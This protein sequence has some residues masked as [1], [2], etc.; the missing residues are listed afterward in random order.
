[1]GT[2][3]LYS[4]SVLLAVVLVI[5]ALMTKNNLDLDLYSQLQPNR[6]LQLYLGAIKSLHSCH[7]LQRCIEE[8]RVAHIIYRLSI[9]LC[10]VSTVAVI[11]VLRFILSLLS[12]DRASL[13]S[14]GTIVRIRGRL[15]GIAVAPE[16]VEVNLCPQASVPSGPRYIGV[17]E[18]GRNSPIEQ[19]TLQSPLD[20]AQAQTR[21]I[22]HGVAVDP[23]LVAQELPPGAR[24]W[25]IS[26]GNIPEVVLNLLH[27]LW[28]L[29]CHLT[30][31][32]GPTAIVP[33]SQRGSSHPLQQSPP[34][35][36]GDTQPG[37]PKTA[38]YDFFTHRGV[39]TSLSPVPFGPSFARC[40]TRWIPD[41]LLRPLRGRHPTLFVL[42]IAIDEATH[43]LEILRLISEASK[44]GRINFSG[45]CKEVSLDKIYA[46]IGRLYNESM[47]IPGSELLILLTGH[48]DS[49]NRMRLHGDEFIDETDLYQFFEQLK[50]QNTHSTVIP[51]ILFDICREGDK[52][53]REPP[54]GIGLLWSCSSG[55]YAHAFRLPYNPR[56]PH[57]CFLLALVMGSCI[58]DPPCTSETFKHR[59][60]EQLDRLIVYLKEVYRLRHSK[61]KCPVC[62]ESEELCKEPLQ[63]I[64]WRS[65]KAKNM[66]GIIML[67]EALLDTEIGQEIHRS[68]TLNP[69][70]RRANKLLPVDQADRGGGLEV[71]SAAVGATTGNSGNIPKAGTN[72]HVRGA[73]LSVHAG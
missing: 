72:G 31:L 16:L 42:V 4:L 40:Y 24:S 23:P 35:D 61:G 17:S 66:G 60:N 29:V 47:N 73:N 13:E 57:S 53:S 50:L 49:A 41:V 28:A 2:N 21:I 44:P 68:I 30:Y 58:N 69:T 27:T 1:M 11:A 67:A 34:L 45:L 71:L 3:S 43:D 65:A 62:L 39:G 38:W 63:S 52:P 18:R 8:N 26:T 48:G 51:T 10:I 20:V 19:C 37:R 54:E 5:A 25:V 70:F 56:I 9:V 32:V 64:D 15:D 14:R 33:G 7:V 6:Q 22:L 46:T 59:V 55:E 36:I 12:R